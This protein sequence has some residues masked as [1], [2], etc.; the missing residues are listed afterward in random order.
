MAQTCRGQI[1]DLP[2]R[3]SRRCKHRRPC[4]NQGGGEAAH[5]ASAPAGGML[6]WK[7]RPSNVN[8]STSGEGER[9]TVTARRSG[10]ASSILA[11]E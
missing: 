8:V 3:S 1:Q 5:K 9:A 10:A 4:R 2:S 7:R 11:A 6:V